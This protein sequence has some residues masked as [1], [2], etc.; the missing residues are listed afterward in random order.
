MLFIY[1]QYTAKPWT[2]TRYNLLLWKTIKETE[3]IQNL[4][5]A[6]IKLE[7][8]EYFDKH[9]RDI[10][11]L[12]DNLKRDFNHKVEKYK[13]ELDKTIKW[14]IT[15][16]GSIVIFIGIAGFVGLLTWSK[17]QIDL[18]EIKQKLIYRAIF[19]H[20]RLR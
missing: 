1:Y 8:I 2:Y 9:I 16:F 4:S 12:E 10:R 18:L 6:E 20:L 3:K 5:N 14:Y 13:N 15:I 19:P 17:S 7:L 11:N